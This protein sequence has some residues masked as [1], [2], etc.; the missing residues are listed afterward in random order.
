MINKVDVFY[1]N[2]NVG[3]IALGKDNIVYFSYSDEW[4]ND[5]FSISPIILPLKKGLFTCK[6]NY[7]K[8]LFGVFGDSLPDS[9]GEL[10]F[11]RFCKKNNISNVNCLDRLAYIGKSG[12]GALEY[13]PHYENKVDL[14]YNLDF[15]QEEVNKILNSKECEDIEKVYRLGGSSGGARPKV[16]V[17]INNEEYIVKFASRLDDKD[18]AE[19]E[20]QY[21]LLAKKCGMNVPDFRLIKGKKNNYFAIKRFDREDKK[22]IH[23]ISVA[24]LLECDFSSPCL[25]YKDL[26]KL[27]K[28]L[29]PKDILEMYRRMVFN[30][31]F[32]NQDD[33]AKNFSFLY[34]ENLKSYT[35]SP[36]YDLTPGKTYFNEHTT[37]VL[38]KGK[39]INDE[40][41]YKIGKMFDIKNDDIKQIIDITKKAKED[42]KVL[43]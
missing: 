25:D 7:F 26:L 34:D 28:V 22:K 42:L 6:T 36:A 39:D 17:K 14:E 33:H 20:Y 38:G 21:T 27:V 37:S 32:D 43:L 4:I 9:W 16:L 10:L 15:I 23:M 19:K 30:V 40:H 3:T 5:G 24:A 11:D 35:L 8:G 31:I 41:F 2:R 12:M 18:I 29:S 13:K 1:H